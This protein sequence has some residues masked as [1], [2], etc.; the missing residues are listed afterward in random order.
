MDVSHDKT[1]SILRVFNPIGV[2][3]TTLKQGL[4]IVLH[5]SFLPFGW[6]HQE[7]LQKGFSG[8][9]SGRFLVIYEICLLKSRKLLEIVIHEHGRPFP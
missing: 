4:T 2:C 5:Q 3:A 9:L 1:G 7:S 6:N 8:R